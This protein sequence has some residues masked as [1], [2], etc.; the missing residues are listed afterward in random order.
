MHPRVGLHQVAFLDESTRRSLITA[1]G[2][3]CST[4]LL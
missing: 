2:L 3:A 4:R 1:A